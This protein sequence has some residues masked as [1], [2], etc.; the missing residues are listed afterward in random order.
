MEHRA[1]VLILQLL[2]PFLYVF[3]DGRRDS[4]ILPLYLTGWALLLCAAISRQAAR[5]AVTFPAYMAAALAGI[6]ATLFLTVV[7]ISASILW[8]GGGTWLHWQ[9]VQ[10]A[11]LTANAVLC[12]WVAVEASMIRMNRKRRTAARENND[13]SWSEHKTLLQHPAAPYL[14]W[15]AVVYTAA[16]LCSCPRLCDLSL[17][18]GILYLISWLAWQQCTVTENYLEET[19]TLAKVPVNKIRRMHRGMILICLAALIPAAGAALLTASMRPYRDLRKADLSMPMY[20][21]MMDQGA[22]SPAEG[23]FEEWMEMMPAEE[24]SFAWPAWMEKLPTV[25]FILILGT[26]LLLAVKAAREYMLEFEGAPEEN[27]DI[28][29]SLEEDQTQKL[30]SS[31]LRIPFGRISEK[32]KV[33]RLYRRTIRRYR[34]EKPKAYEAPKEIEAGTAFPTDFDSTSLHESYERARYGK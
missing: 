20:T 27:G 13:I 9:N 28:S 11:V 15:F 31:G 24:C 14:L 34:K 26:V 21:D 3:Y 30:K 4:Q 23:G 12:L 29:R 5:K 19:R 16:L 1:L 22:I 25:F 18:N 7:L 2:C 10:L 33:R 17:L 6:G 8:P 32:E